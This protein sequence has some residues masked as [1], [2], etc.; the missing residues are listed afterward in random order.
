MDL[1]L[2]REVQGDSDL[3]VTGIFEA[4]G[5]KIKKIQQN[6]GQGNWRATK[7]SKFPEGAQSLKIA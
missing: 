2:R 5:E 1:G 6:R 4:R 7:T 3:K